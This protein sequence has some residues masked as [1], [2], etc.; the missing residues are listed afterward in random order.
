MLH[1]YPI[2]PSRVKE[3]GG[4]KRDVAR[5]PCQESKTQQ[6]QDKQREPTSSNAELVGQGGSLCR[7]D[8]WLLCVVLD[9]REHLVRSELVARIEKRQLNDESVLDDFAAQ[10][11]YER[12]GGSG[13][14]PG[15]D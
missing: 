13:G 3:A 15:S 6:L 7:P 4:P 2:R 12:R 14:S 11:L 10:L 9:Q 1:S 5:H 8:A